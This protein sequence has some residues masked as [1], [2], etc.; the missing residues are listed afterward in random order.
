MNEPEYYNDLLVRLEELFY[1]EL[2]DCAPFKVELV[3]VDFIQSRDIKGDTAAEVVQNCIREIKEAGFVK[4]IGYDISGMGI[5]FELRIRGCVHLPKE[6]KLRKNGVKP[7]ICPIANMFLDQLIEKLGY[8]T[9]Y[10]ASMDID[11]QTG[12]CKVWSAIYETEEQIGQ[13]CNWHEE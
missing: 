12:E 2:S 5:K 13:V 6:V 9:T 4:E 3:G 10:L 8:E 1:H 7:Y 11:E